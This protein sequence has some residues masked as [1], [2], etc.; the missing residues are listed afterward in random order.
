MEQ[1][2]L[3]KD[4]LAAMRESHSMLSCST[5]RRTAGAHLGQF[6]ANGTPAD[7]NKVLGQLCERENVFVSVVG[8]LT[9][10]YP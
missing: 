1:W 8:D 5:Q 6:A 4:A 2:A 10:G 7:N 9:V 3:H